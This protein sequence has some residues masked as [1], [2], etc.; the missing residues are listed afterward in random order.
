MLCVM[1]VGFV[2]KFDVQCIILCVMHNSTGSESPYCIG[3]RNTTWLTGEFFENV[4]G[5]QKD[6]ILFHD[7]NDDKLCV[8]IRFK[9]VHMQIVRA[10]KCLDMKRSV[11]ERTISYN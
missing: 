11:C 3:F 2:G 9:D 8:W 6:E 1:F 10:I 4:Y 5:L 7:D